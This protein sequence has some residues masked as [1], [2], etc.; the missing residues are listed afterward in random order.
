MLALLEFV[1]HLSA[2]SEKLI[3]L[4]TDYAGLSRYLP[5]QL[6]SIRIIEKNNNETITQEELVFSTIIKNKIIQQS[7]HSKLSK[8][9]L[10][11]EIILGPATG[12]TI[13]V[14]FSS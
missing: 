8:T 1:L 7:K 12:S 13:L 14:T 6:K 10:K 5:N 3:E 2:P 4:A 11:S 9:E